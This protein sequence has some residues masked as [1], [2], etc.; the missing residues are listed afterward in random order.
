MRRWGDSFDL[1][2]DYALGQVGSDWTVVSFRSDAHGAVTRIYPGRDRYE[3]E[4][5]KEAF[6][7]ARRRP[8]ATRRNV[9]PVDLPLATRPLPRPPEPLPPPRQPGLTR[10]ATARERR[11]YRARHRTL[12]RR[13]AL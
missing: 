1:G 8:K 12:I 3:T 5:Q 10:R 9:P 6:D 2:A 11:P 4:D 13:R 7:F